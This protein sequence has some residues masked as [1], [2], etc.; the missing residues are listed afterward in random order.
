MWCTCFFCQETSCSSVLVWKYKQTHFQS[1]L[2]FC[3][4]K[5]HFIS[6]IES[7]VWNSEMKNSIFLLCPFLIFVLIFVE[8][9][10]KLSYYA[11]IISCLHTNRVIS[12]S[13][14]TSDIHFSLPDKKTGV[15]GNLIIQKCIFWS[16]M[17][18]IIR[19]FGLDSDLVF[20][21]VWNWTFWFWD[22]LVL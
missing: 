22:F 7:H 21:K 9:G 19:L 10:L 13:N 11:F 14:L 2:D 3:V 1:W 12:A 17:S 4:W 5:V 8:Y 15:T 6:Y 16:L 20:K 18:L